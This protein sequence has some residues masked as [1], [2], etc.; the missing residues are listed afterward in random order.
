MLVAVAAPNWAAARGSTSLLISPLVLA[1][2]RRRSSAD[3]N[4]L[5]LAP[6]KVET[7]VSDWPNSQVA[8]IPIQPGTPATAALDAIASSTA[9]TPF[10]GED[11]AFSAAIWPATRSST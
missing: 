4:L 6:I 9:S 2:P 1:S 7:S 10:K 8:P 11:D 5:L 3:N